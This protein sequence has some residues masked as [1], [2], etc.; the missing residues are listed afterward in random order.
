MIISFFVLS[1]Y[2]A[3]KTVYILIISYLIFLKYC[4][5]SMENALTFKYIM[6][7]FVQV[8]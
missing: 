4:D 1:K 6:D 8:N 3:K 2:N 5:I 7:S